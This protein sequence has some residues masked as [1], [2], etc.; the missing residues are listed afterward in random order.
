MQLACV[1]KKKKEA[2]WK[3]V[4]FTAG[5]YCMCI[6]LTREPNQLDPVLR[7]EKKET[8]IEFL[9]L[10]DQ[11]VDSRNFLADFRTNFHYLATYIHK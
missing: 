5:S 3:R 1:S 6:V 8:G 11:S 10:L 9:H 4:R 2:A 7:R